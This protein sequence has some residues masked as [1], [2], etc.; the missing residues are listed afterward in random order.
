MG[1]ENSL[2]GEAT[3]FPALGSENG[4]AQR[5]KAASPASP[6]GLTISAP[7]L[8]PVGGNYKQNAIGST[9]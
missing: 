8:P 4:L 1:V 6:A 9:H 2:G 3:G 5:K 7:K